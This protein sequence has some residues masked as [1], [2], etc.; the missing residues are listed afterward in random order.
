MIFFVLFILMSMLAPVSYLMLKEEQNKRQGRERAA[1]ESTLIEG[2]VQLSS[3]CTRL[4][5]PAAPPDFDGAF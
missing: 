1:S 4:C 3:A 2:K 5:P